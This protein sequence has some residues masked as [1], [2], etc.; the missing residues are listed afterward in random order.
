MT[1]VREGLLSA[2]QFSSRDVGGQVTIFQG[3]RDLPWTDTG[4]EHSLPYP[5][6]GL[7]ESTIAADGHVSG[8]G[9]LSAGPWVPPK[10]C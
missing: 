6:Q 8:G 2:S 5:R 10:P 3:E 9:G 4:P 1:K 7:P